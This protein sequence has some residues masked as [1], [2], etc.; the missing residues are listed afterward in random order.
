[1]IY[2]ISENKEFAPEYKTWLSAGADVKSTCTHV[3]H[4]GETRLVGTGV[5]IDICS[6]RKL[7]DQSAHLPYLMLS[8]RSSLAKKGFTL[9]NGVGIIDADYPNEIGMLMTNNTKGT[10]LINCGDRIG[11]L[12]LVKTQRLPG[13]VTCKAS[14][15]GGFGSTGNNS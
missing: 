2:L 11:Q 10:L 4:A 5:R 3:F 13:V 12:I 8:I 7:V 6:T 14:R 1:M 9:A 15:E